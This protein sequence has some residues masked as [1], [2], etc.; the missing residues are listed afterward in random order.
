MQPESSL[1]FSQQP[2]NSRNS[3]HF[4][5]PEGS[6]PCS[7]QPITGPYTERESVYAFPSSLLNINF[8]TVLSPMPNVIQ[9]YFYH[10]VSPTIPLYALLFYT[11]WYMPRP[12]PRSTSASTLII[13]GDE[14]KQCSSSQRRFFRHPDISSLL[15]PKY[16]P[17]H[18][19][20]QNSRP[21]C[22]LLMCGTKFY[23]HTKYEQKLQVLKRKT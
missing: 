15:R 3:P 13:Y 20:L 22:I 4:M 12:S 5:Q 18:P 23:T 6:L 16:L 8:H 9:V 21:M 1:P 2:I 17:L 7:Q 14:C 10:R 11:K 19:I